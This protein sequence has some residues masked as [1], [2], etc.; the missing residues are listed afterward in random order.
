MSELYDEELWQPG[1]DETPESFRAQLELVTEQRHKREFVIAVADAVVRT[2]VRDEAKRITDAE[3]VDEAPIPEPTGLSALLVEDD[4]VE[5]W[6]MDGLWPANG[7]V[8]LAAGAKSGKTTTVGNVVRCLADGDRFLNAYAVEKL[9]P[10]E[11]VAILDYEMPRRKVRQW[12]LEQNIENPDR[13]VVWTERGRATQ[14]DV[15]NDAVRVKWVARLHEANVKVWVID[16]LSPI[17]SACGIEENDNTA[18]GAILDGI[19]TVAVAAGVQEVLLVHHMGHGAERSRGASRLVGWPDVNWRLI[20]PKDEKN[21]N[22]EPDPEGPRYFAANGRDVDVREG[23]LVF[24]D[25]NRHLLYMEGGRKRDEL[26]T[27]IG[28]LLVWVRE[29]PDVSGRQIEA[30]MKELAVG[31]EAARRALKA[32]VSKGYLVE[33]DLGGRKMGHTI[34]T[35]GRMQIM[36]MADTPA[37]DDEILSG[38]AG[39]E[40]IPC[41]TEGCGYHI[42]PAEQADG[43]RVCSLCRQE[44]A[45]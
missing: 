30:R 40:D 17:L 20:R 39:A 8:L 37:T 2:R 42:Q 41:P 19:N 43:R 26:T 44:Q 7:N 15:R 33:R 14:F 9:L 32:A 45:A 10:G 5:A 23:R 18:V 22:A 31:R 36:G 11:T 34:T 3:K 29:N 27:N 12:L 25:A 13:V 21:P 38:I 24:N 4:D 16:C 6:R 1:W 28:K 35:S